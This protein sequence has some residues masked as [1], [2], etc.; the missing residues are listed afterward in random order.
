MSESSPLQGWRLH[1]ARL[2]ALVLIVAFSAAVFYYSSRIENIEIYGY[3]GVFLL[4]FLTN[5]TI[6]FPAPSVAVAFTMG[7]VLN[8]LGVALAAGAG[9]ALGELTG[10]VAGYT[11]QGFIPHGETYQRLENAT[12]RYGGWAILVLSLIPNPAFDIAGAAAGAL[13]M[14][15]PTFL[16]FAFVGK[17]IKMLVLALA[18]AY[19]M[20]WILAALNGI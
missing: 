13:R 6:I 20:D 3:P 18:G 4:S 9:A 10:Y 7:S 16:T 5:A 17:T 19:S 2:A 1:A 15:V 11:G 8:P 12:R 14:P